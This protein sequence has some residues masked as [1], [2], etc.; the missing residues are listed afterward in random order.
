MAS[1]PVEVSTNSDLRSTPAGGSKE[2][3]ASTPVEVSAISET[4]RGSGGFAASVGGDDGGGADGVGLEFQKKDLAP[5]ALKARP[6]V[7]QVV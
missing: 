3:V 5:R 7:E 6:R 2:V 1:T 4:G